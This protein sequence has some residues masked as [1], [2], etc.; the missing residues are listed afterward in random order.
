M[1]HGKSCDLDLLWLAA[2]TLGK[3]VREFKGQLIVDGA[4]DSC[5]EWNPLKFER[6]AWDLEN[7]L[8]INL[9]WHVDGIS[10]HVEGYPPHFELFA[11]NG[12]YRDATRMRVGV[13]LAAY[14][15]FGKE[16]LECSLSSM[17]VGQS[18]QP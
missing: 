9:S 14:M 13:Y 8:G 12:G 17:P 15:S 3:K 5:R 2:T 6:D 1:L 16:A 10:A 7:K 11:S 18:T 4:Y